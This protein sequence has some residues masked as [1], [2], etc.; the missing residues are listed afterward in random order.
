MPAQRNMK[1]PVIGGMVAHGIFFVILLATT[2]SGLQSLGSDTPSWFPALFVGA[3]AVT[4][5]GIISGAVLYANL[6]GKARLNALR[7]ARPGSTIVR[8]NWSS[9]ILAPFLKP[10]PLLRHTNYRGF[11]VDA[12]ADSTG[13]TLWRGGHKIVDLGLLPWDRIRSV[14]V[15]SVKAVIGKRVSPILVIE[16]DPGI[17]QYQSRI[18]LISTHGT[19]DAGVAKLLARRIP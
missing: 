2:V 17:G 8:G 6:I 1:N 19:A 18:E 16:V 9:G 12:T 10:G 11:P 3:P 4:V 13:I 15:E 5:V 7:A 14:S